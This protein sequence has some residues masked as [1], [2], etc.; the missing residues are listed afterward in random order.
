MQD[1]INA[2]FPYYQQ[3]RRQL[4]Q[5]PELRYQEVKT[6]ALITQELQKLNLGVQ[7]Q[8]GQTGV[9]AIL[10]RGIGKTVALRAD[11][12]A[13]PI[14][15]D[16]QLHYQSKNKGIMHACGHDGHVATLLAVAHVLCEFKHQFSGKIKF[17]FQPAEE[18]G[19]GALAMI[20][21]GVLE[22]PTVDAIF[23]YHNYP[24]A[25]V[26]N[27][28]VKHDC[29]M[30]GNVEFN[31]TI[32]GKGGHAA[33]PNLANN[34]ITIAAHF[35]QALQTVSCSLAQK[36]EPII[37][38]VTQLNSGTAA[39]VIPTSTNLIGTIR[40]ASISHSKEAQNI[41]KKTL[42]DCVSKHN[43]TASIEINDIYPPTINT[44]AETDFVFNQAT[45]LLGKDRVS[46][47][48]MSGRASEDFSFFLQKVPGCYFFI[49]NGNGASCHN[50]QYDF[51]DTL[52]PDA[53]ALLS[54]LAI[55]YLNTTV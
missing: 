9:V 17:I 32:H 54:N 16:S 3:L 33:V 24:N 20:N 26:G 39:N 5:M 10:D 50:P 53:I 55:N 8:V 43:A 7:T 36:E 2:I 11:M 25:P 13:L 15:E 4:H 40:A 49:G 35:I 29:T 51:N 42:Q 37:L 12:D 27:I 28:L 38:T 22:N 1:F 44:K 34:P 18:G 6:A 41:L 14:T 47:K 45:Q 30:Y 48:H 31:I 46:L 19:A 52:L 23:A 21:D